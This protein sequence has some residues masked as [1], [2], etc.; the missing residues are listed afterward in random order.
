M[1]ATLALPA[2]DAPAARAPGGVPLRIWLGYLAM[3]VGNFMAVLDIQIVASSIHSLQAGLSASAD[4]VQWIQTA[5]L[6]AEIIAIPL[7]GYLTQLLSTRVY[8]AISALGFTLASAACAFSWSLGSMVVFRVLQGFLGGGMIPAVFAAMYLL[9][10][11]ERRLLPLVLT[12]MTTMLAPSLGPTLGGYI[13]DA[14]SWRWLFLVNLLPGILVAIAVWRLVDIDR[15]QPALLR[16]IDLPGLVLMAVFLGCFEYALDEGPRHDWFADDSVAL[17][18]LAAATAGVLF[19]RRALR[20]ADPIVDLR[21]FRDRNFAVG[22]VISAVLGMSLYSL[23]YL[24]PMFLSQVRGYNPG[25]IGEVMM[26]QGLSMMAAAPL[27]GRLARIVDPRLLMAFGLGLVALG[28]W[29][30]SRLTVDWGFHEYIGPQVLRGFGLVC[31]F[32]PLTNL[33]LGTLP[34]TQ[35]KNASGLYNV[36]RNLGGAIGLASLTTLMNQRTWL[37]WQQ[38]AE[39]TRLSREPVRQA[40]SDLG[41]M[42]APT[43]GGQGGDGAVGLLA[44]QAQL[45]AAAMSFGDLNL[46]LAIA[47]LLTL[48]LLPLVRGVDMD[49]EI[50]GAH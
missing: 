35:V 33:S 23:V 50:E 28:C 47:V 42:L 31:C 29:G 16:S 19:F 8:Y 37:H 18:L 25:Q 32:I 13:A 4:E 30:N 34:L 1:N 22:S 48:P 40:L 38:L 15:P 12:G 44:Q 45:Q 24:T 7:S 43:L 2:A 46:L 49:R 14:T 36:M 10:P 20:I 39:S 3:V 11:P 9:F 27:V 5:Y 17:C 21:A 41:G 6:I 26:V